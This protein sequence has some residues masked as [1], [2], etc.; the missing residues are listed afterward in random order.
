MKYFDTHVHFF[1][2]K[3]ARKALPRLREISGC[4]TYT[5][6]TRGDTLE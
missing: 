5:A 6:G 2:D 1:P 4:P 3:L